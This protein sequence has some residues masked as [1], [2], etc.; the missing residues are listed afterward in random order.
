MASKALSDEIEQNIAIIV[1]APNNTALSN[2]GVVL[3][4]QQAIER[5][6]DLIH[7]T[8]AAERD[9]QYGL[10]IADKCLTFTKMLIEHETG[11]SFHD[12]SEYV[13]ANG[14]VDTNL[15]DL[16]WD[17]VLEKSFYDFEAFMFYME[18]NRPYFK[19]FYEPRMYTKDGRPALKIVAEEL[20]NLEYRKYDFLGI[21]MPSRTGKST[22]CIFF[23][24]W[25]ALRNPNSHSAM[26]GHANALVKGFYKELLNLITSSDY[27]YYDIYSH[28]WPSKILVQ[29]KSA[30]DFTI[31]LD[32]PDRFATL[33]CRS[34]DSTWTGAVDI[35]ADG[36]LYV[37]DLVRDRQ[38]SL[39]PVRMEET[40]QEYLNKMVDRKN[41]GAQELM[42]GTLWNVLDPLE[43]LRKLYEGNPRYKFLRLPALDENDESN[44]DYVIKGFSTQYYREM[45]ER[46]DEP[47]W[48]SK[49]QQHPFVREGLVFPSDELRY[50]DGVVIDKD[51][52]RVFAICDPAF[53]GGDNLS[54]PI[55]FETKSGR[56][57]IA[58]WIYDKRT[59]KFT[60]P[61]IVSAIQKYTITELR[62]EKNGAGLM[63]ADAIKDEMKQRNVIHCKVVSAMAPNKMSKEDKIKGYSD[64][65]KDNFEFLPVNVEKLAASEVEGVEIFQRDS[66]YQRAMDDL[67]M[68]T[69]EGKNVHDDSADSLAQMAIAC[70]QK[71]NGQI[72]V[73]HNVY[74]EEGL[75][76]F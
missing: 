52:E 9:I 50:F 25:K 64:Y 66:D 6:K 10:A 3:T 27:T 39:S 11:M 32:E 68:Y 4:I 24:C 15:Y 44:F 36:L 46:L 5:L 62:I 41:D 70:E 55:C 18:K 74:G 28:F 60:I 49:F 23:L 16:Y 7:L 19:K 65:V 42:V 48:Q 63:L 51:I 38:H 69:A 22:I 58:K 76:W 67:S 1:D 17:L 59:L 73:L 57:R 75:G 20:Q 72:K 54:M 26:G 34:I 43:R 35:S 40:F 14:D 12:F 8:L 21:S 47:E 2:A 33:T 61:R 30:E 53:G 71:A 31:T 45:R 13:I 29:D 37:D 56:K